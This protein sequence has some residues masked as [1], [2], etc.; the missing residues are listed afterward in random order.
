MPSLK[1]FSAAEEED[2]QLGLNSEAARF[3]PEAVEK[4]EDPD[5]MDEKDESG[6]EGDDVKRDQVE[7]EVE[8]ALGEEEVSDSKER[9]QAS[10]EGEQSESE[11]L[12]VDLADIR[13]DVQCS[14][15]LGIIR[16]TR[17][18][19][20]CLHRF[21]R[22]CIDKSMRLGNNECPTCR[23]HCASR[24]SLRDDPNFDALIATLFENI[25]Q[26]EEEEMAFLQDDEA[27]NK[28]IQASIA[29]VSQ[30]QSEALAKRKPFGK[31]AAVLSRSR[32]SGSG[33]RRRRNC[34]NLEQDT[35]E[36]HDDDD[37]NKRGK[38]SSS[39]EPCAEILLRK[40]KKRSTTQPS[41]SNA[42]N[43]DNCAGNGTEQTHQRDSRGISPV[44]MWNSEILAW[45]R[46]GT[47]SNTR[48]GNN[49]QGAISKRN[50]RLN[51]LVEYL[52][53]LEGN[54]VELDIHLKLISLDT[55]GLLNLLEPY[56]CCRP[57]LLVKQLREY[58]A[59]QM[60]LK[61]EEVELF[62]SKDGDRVIGNKTSTE[63]MQ[64]LQDDETLSKLKVDCILSHGYM[65][66]A[67]RDK[68]IG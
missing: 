55:E 28:Q 1:N 56:L 42:N 19:M 64:S 31:D 50:A 41:S 39:D 44:L 33:S 17:T 60:K 49:N 22:E 54:S 30:R 12:Y 11:Y 14:I 3:N 38:D 57:T 47:R 35:S 62:V 6:D 7:A 46:G 48:Q 59:R 36:A 2:D 32:R 21:C 29:Q 40:R 45:G 67:F 4:E 65:I 34:R 24:R 37:Q 43:N 52:G 20:E 18:V 66:V 53:S 16:K 23:K 13:R 10:S 61:A 51:R 68:R 58:V 15:C 9:S 26:F 8:E 27:R 25:D 5:K 63:K